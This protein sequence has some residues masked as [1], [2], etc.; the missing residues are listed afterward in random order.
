MCGSSLLVALLLLHLQH[1]TAGLFIF[2]IGDEPGLIIHVSGC[3]LCVFDGTDQ[4]LGLVPDGLNP[5]LHIFNSRGA[6]RIKGR[7][8]MRLKVR[9]QDTLIG[10]G[11]AG[12]IDFH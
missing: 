6:F 7:N 1:R 2:L 11:C 3:R 12:G 8:S 10:A 4:R 5:G 9:R